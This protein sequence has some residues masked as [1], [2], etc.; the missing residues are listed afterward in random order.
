LKELLARGQLTHGD[1]LPH[2]WSLPAAGWRAGTREQHPRAHI[3]AGS[4]W[5]W[6]HEM[7]VTVAAQ[8]FSCDA[9]P[10]ASVASWKG[11]RVGSRWT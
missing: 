6:M 7:Y 9:G 10:A 3:V 4:S 8:A 1:V 11:H 2:V 5:S